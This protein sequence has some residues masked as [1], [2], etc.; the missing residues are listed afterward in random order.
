MKISFKKCVIFFN[1]LISFIFYLDTLGLSPTKDKFIK[2]L[3]GT[4]RGI[5]KVLCSNAIPIDGSLP[6]YRMEETDVSSYIS[7]LHQ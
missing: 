6:D 3:S 2:A 1:F 7:H 5:P 4:L